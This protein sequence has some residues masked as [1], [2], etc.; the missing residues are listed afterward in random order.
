MPYIRGTFPNNTTGEEF[1]EFNLE[2]AGTAVYGRLLTKIKAFLCGEASAAT[3]TAVGSANGFIRGLEVKV[4]ATT[5][6][7]TV[8]FTN[9]TEFSITATGETEISGTLTGSAPNRFASVNGARFKCRIYEGSN[10]FVN[11]DTFTFTTTSSPLGAQAYDVIS[12]TAK[13]SGSF[14]GAIGETPSDYQNL[15]GV[16]ATSVAVNQGTLRDLKYHHQSFINAKYYVTFR[17]GGVT[18][19]VRDSTG[20]IVGG[21]G[22]VGTPWEWGA[23]GSRFG[24][25]VSGGGVVYTTTTVNGSGIPTAGS[26]YTIT[27]VSTPLTTDSHLSRIVVLRAR[28]YNN[29]DTIY[30]TLAQRSG[31]ASTRFHLELSV[32]R[33]HDQN[34]PTFSQISMSPPAKIRHSQGAHLVDYTIIGN[35]RYF[36]VLTLPSVSGDHQCMGGG[37]LLPHATPIASEEYLWP[38]FCGGTVTEA[39]KP[40]GSAWVS[41]EATL[42]FFNPQ[43]ATG[44]STLNVVLPGTNITWVR[45]INISTAT[46]PNTAPD[47]RTVTNFARTFPWA[48][49]GRLGAIGFPVLIDSGVFQ[50]TATL[51]VPHPGGVCVSNASGSGY[52]GEFPGLFFIGNSVTAQDVSAGDTLNDGAYLVWAGGY[53]LNAHVANKAAFALE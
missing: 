13:G 2:G 31:A 39:N 29:E 7:W 6:T 5:R 27:P 50:Q 8:L 48:L 11:G 16:V 12:D 18:F 30:F 37:L 22:T 52:I 14:K 41:G 34:T 28:G 19:D 10:P 1:K 46:D 47:P 32:H 24:L 38:A 49:I 43:G 51:K 35:G 17:S 42:P 3:L 4:G 9:A 20:A 15:V 26:Y 44:S 40:P 33:N 45:A 25:T 23:T 53:G 36:Y 21:M